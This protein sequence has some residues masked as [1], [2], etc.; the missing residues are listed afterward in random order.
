MRA[1]KY[2]LGCVCFLVFLSQILSCSK[3]E[4]PPPPT[5]LADSVAQDP[6]YRLGKWYS[7]TDSGSIPGYNHNT[8]LDTIWFMGDSLAEWSGFGGNP[9]VSWPTYF[10]GPYHIVYIAPDPLHTGKF[11]TVLHECGMTLGGDTFTIY[12]P[13]VG[14]QVL[15]EE[16]IKKKS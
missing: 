7:I 15:V 11:D 4:S 14:N 2:S 13:I 8:R 5:P 6:A 10:S 1:I 9:Y 3:K 12:W 16:Y